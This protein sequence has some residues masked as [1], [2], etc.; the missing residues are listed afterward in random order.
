M[1]PDAPP[2]PAAS[3]GPEMA[4]D[5][6]LCVERVT[7]I[8]PAFSAWEADVLPLNYTRAAQRPYFEV[9]PRRQIWAVTCGNTRARGIGRRLSVRVVRSLK[10]SKDIS[11]D[12]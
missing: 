11:R 1:E 2:Q 5:L 7:G 12:S 3:T 8:E 4:A 10:R 6:R 9:R